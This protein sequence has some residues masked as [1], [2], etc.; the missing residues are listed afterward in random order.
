MESIDFSMIF[1]ALRKMAKMSRI[2]FF[3]ESWQCKTFS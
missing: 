2:I 1:A 3:Y